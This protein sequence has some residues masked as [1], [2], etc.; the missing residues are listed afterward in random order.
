[1]SGHC[2]QPKY[3]THKNLGGK[4]SSV[5]TIFMFSPN[6]FKLYNSA[7]SLNGFLKK[8]QQPSNQFETLTNVKQLRN[9]NNFSHPLELF[10]ILF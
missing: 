3:I 9:L 6:S 4:K 10:S 5:V 8:M 1:M 2:G 7:Y